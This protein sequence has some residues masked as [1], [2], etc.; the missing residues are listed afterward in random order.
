MCA[1]IVQFYTEFAFMRNSELRQKLVYHSRCELF[2]KLMFTTIASTAVIASNITLF[3][4][5]VCRNGYKSYNY[6]SHL[7]QTVLLGVTNLN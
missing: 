3:A 1:T 4:G 6:L 5:Y 2:H 7:I